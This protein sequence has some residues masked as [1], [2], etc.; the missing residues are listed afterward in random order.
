MK[1][2]VIGAGGQLGTD[3]VEA[4]Q[5][6]GI[7]VVA[8]RR[9]ELDVT[10]AP[11]VEEALRCSHADVVVN[12]AAYVRVDQAETEVEEAFRA[13]TIG[14]LNVARASADHKALAVYI[15]TDYVFD[16][17]KGSPYIEKDE[18]R[19]INVYGESKLAGEHLVQQAAPEH[20][21]ARVAGL[22]GKAGAS[23]KGGNF[24]ETILKRAY[25][26]GALRVVDD[27]RMSPTYTYD[28]ARGII[29]LIQGGAR[30]VHHLTNA[31]ICSW[32]DFAR[33]AVLLAAPNASI[34][35]VDSSAYPTTARRPRNSSLA[36]VA[37]T[38]R[39][40]PWQEALDAYLIE[41]GH[42]DVVAHVNA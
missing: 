28:A 23:G 13:N 2:A 6:T 42:I 8:F 18:V 35:P 33:R 10:N 34:E 37:G 22:F 16:G 15:S 3:L 39:L 29:E 24:I 14:A 41:K 20:L 5:A 27:T 21:I 1:V 32:Y 11:G 4:L 7:D 31:G 38:P 12:C 40:R 17:E 25:E 9:D 26:G 36:S 30:G 19:P